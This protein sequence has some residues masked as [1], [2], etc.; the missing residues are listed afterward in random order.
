MS[1]IAGKVAGED[2]VLDGVL[3]GPELF[4]L[5]N[6]SLGE[7]RAS[8]V[9]FRLGGWNLAGEHTSTYLI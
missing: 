6:G 4:S 9:H 5:S 3:D 8:P 7:G 2:A 1:D